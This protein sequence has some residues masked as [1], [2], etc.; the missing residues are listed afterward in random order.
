MPVNFAVMTRTLGDQTCRSELSAP[1]MRIAGRKRPDRIGWVL[2]HHSHD[3][4]QD[5]ERLCRKVPE[6][7]ANLPT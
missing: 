3:C 2:D 1:D 5:V 4:D 7:P 6:L